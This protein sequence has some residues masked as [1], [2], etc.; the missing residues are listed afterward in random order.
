MQDDHQ[1][2]NQE[3]QGSS[4]EQIKLKIELDAEAIL[5]TASDNGPTLSFSFQLY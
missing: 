3:H 2:L 5:F 1:L 4:L